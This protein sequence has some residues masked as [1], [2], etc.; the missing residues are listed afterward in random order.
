MSVSSHQT[1]RTRLVWRNLAEWLDAALVLEQRRASYRKNR[2]R[3]L[4]VQA[5]PVSLIW[6]ERAEETLQR[7]LDLLTSSS[8]GFGRPLRGQREFSPHT[9]LIMAIK[10]RMKLLERQRD[11]D[12]MLDG[13]NSRHRFS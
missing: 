10:N 7:A 6:D 3:I 5:L 12:S 13:H 4:H 2:Q 8:S 1:P 9:P 11:M